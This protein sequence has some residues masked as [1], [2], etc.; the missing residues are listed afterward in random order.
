M[1]F[2]N[3]QSNNSHSF[4]CLNEIVYKALSL[5]SGQ[6]EFGQLVLDTFPFGWE[7]FCCILRY[8]VM[9]YIST[10]ICPVYADSELSW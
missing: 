4:I 3:K 7:A 10:K 2:L 6:K 8:T 1:G 9:Y 5:A